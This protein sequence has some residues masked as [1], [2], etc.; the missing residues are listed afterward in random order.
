MTFL[1]YQLGSRQITTAL[2]DVVITQGTA[3][4]GASQEFIDKFAGASGLTI[5]AAF[6]W[7][8]GGTSV[9]LDIETALGEGAAWLPLARFDFSTSS[10]TKI[11][12]VSGLTPRLSALT[13]ATLSANTAVDGLIGDRLRARLTTV[14]TYVSTLLDVRVQAR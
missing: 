12:T 9:Q 6:T 10:A 13:S 8:S 4:N 14:G 3:S 1:P 5:M 11:L 7:G 2:S